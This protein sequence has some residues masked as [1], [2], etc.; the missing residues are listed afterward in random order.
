LICP[1][2]SYVTLSCVN[3]SLAY[4]NFDNHSYTLQ[5]QPAQ[6]KNIQFIHTYSLYLSLNVTASAQ[7][8][9]IGLTATPSV[10]QMLSQVGRAFDTHDPAPRAYR[11]V[12]MIRAI[13]NSLSVTEHTHS[14]IRS[15]SQ[16]LQS[17]RILRRRD[18][19]HEH[20]RATRS[21]HSTELLLQG[22]YV[23]LL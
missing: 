10:N 1:L 14:V 8:G 17:F 22:H 11:R 2:F 16:T 7:N 5:L 21:L 3:T 6:T 20:H 15:C 9:L 23:T 4:N 19:W 18:A 12:N 13:T